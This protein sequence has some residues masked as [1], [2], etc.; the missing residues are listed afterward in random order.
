MCLTNL[1]SRFDFTIKVGIELEFYSNNEISFF[2]ELIAQRFILINLVSREEGDKQ[3]EISTTPT[4]DFKHLLY[5]IHNFKNLLDGIA[6][7]SAK[8]CTDQPGSALHVHVS[9]HNRESHENITNSET[10]LRSFI[11]GGLC[12]LMRSSMLCFAPNVDSYRRFQYYDK[13]TPRFVNWGFRDNKTNAV[14]VTHKTVEHRVAGADANLSKVLESILHAIGYGISN[15]V[16]PGAPNYKES[17]YIDAFCDRLPLS[18]SEAVIQS[19]KNR[20]P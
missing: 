16:V 6:D 2:E 1:N 19:G 8:P 20:F 18:Y 14:R 3:Y 15:E 11:V 9:L 12:Q 13:F 10:T 17:Q 7:F 4:D 5:E